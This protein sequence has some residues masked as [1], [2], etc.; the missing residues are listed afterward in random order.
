MAKNKNRPS[1]GTDI[2]ETW[3]FCGE[4]E[5]EPQKEMVSEYSKIVQNVSVIHEKFSF[6]YFVT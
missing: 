6:E 1:N 2:F 4:I 5:N 3:S